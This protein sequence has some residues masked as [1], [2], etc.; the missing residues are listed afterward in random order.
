[1]K[2]QWLCSTTAAFS[3]LLILS[4]CG[5]ARDVLPRT[6]DAG[7]SYES[8]PLAL[9]EFHGERASGTN[10]V[11]IDTSA[12]AQGY[13]AVSAHS[14]KRLKMQVVYGSVKYNYD[15]P[16]DGTPAVYPLQSGSGAY[17]FRVMQNTTESKYIELYSVQAEVKLASEFEPFLRPNQIVNYGADSACVALAGSLAS[18][19][20]NEVALV[21]SV[22]DYIKNGV[23]YDYEK[24]GSDV[25]GYLPDPDATLSEGRGIC[26]DYAALAAAMLRSQGIP[27]KVITGYVS[28]GAVYHAWNM[29]YLQESGWITVEIKAPKNEWKT[30]DLTFA[31]N[32]ADEARI[33][34]GKD[35]VQRYVY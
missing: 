18:Q 21:A 26:F 5:A 14:G 6:Q 8:P 7:G 27:T 35:Y 9:S 17:M 30:I 2:K 1:M 16:Q 15:L 25:T 32:G 34:N 4:C 31:A 20:K 19:A 10:G 12:T 3:F 13:V 28:G 11:Y 22:Y 23:T 24:A 29:I 33:G